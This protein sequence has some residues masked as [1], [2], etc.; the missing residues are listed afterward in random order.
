MIFTLTELEHHPILFEVS[1]PPG[2][3]TFSD[4][5]TQTTDLIASGSATL[6]H[7][8]LGEIRVRGQIK[9]GMTTVCDR[10][11]ESAPLAFDSEFDFFYRP[12]IKKGA[13][14]EV[15]LEEGEIDISF[16]EGDGVKLEDVLREYVLLSQPMRAL[17]QDG[18]KGLCP[19]CGANLNRAACNCA[20]TP[21]SSPWAALKDL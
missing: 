14:G 10:C 7:N 9:V 16:Y 11:L 13:H 20:P 17:C 18:C 4:E 15:H 1:Y 6:L 2:E 5:L 8:T 21:R 19:Q 12:V 3:L